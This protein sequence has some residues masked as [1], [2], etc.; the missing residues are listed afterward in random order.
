[1][2]AHFT[3]LDGLVLGGYFLITMAVGLAFWRRSR[4]VA[5]FTAAEGSLPG[6]LTGLSILGTYISS[7]S[8]LAL[9]G[10]AFAGNWNPFVFSL[11]LPLA[12]WIAVKYFLPFYRNSGHVSAY[13]HLEERFGPW[14][15]IYASSCYLLTQFARIGTVT[16]LMALPMQVLLGWD[17]RLIILVT[18]VVTTL[19][20]FVGDGEETL[21]VLHQLV[22]VLV[23]VL[24]HKVEDIFLQDHL[25]QLDYV[26]M[27]EF[28]E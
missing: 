2:K 15:R 7:I 6:W 28:H 23:K 1:M 9:P 20:T 27:M 21:P 16:Y 22:H 12:T 5:G 4:S 24:E 8:F 17:I 14:A 13:A 10:R 3:L 11:S 18:G 19:Y 25:I 26:W